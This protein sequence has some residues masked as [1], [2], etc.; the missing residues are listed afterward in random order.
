MIVERYENQV[1]L[2][3]PAAV[4]EQLRPTAP[5]QARLRGSTRPTLDYNLSPSG[6]W[7]Q[8]S[9]WV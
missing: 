6:S 4:C 9:Y 7:D 2:A 3:L 5:E 8:F 1:D